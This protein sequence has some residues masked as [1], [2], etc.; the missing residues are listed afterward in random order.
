MKRLL[1]ICRRKSF[2]ACSFAA[3][4][5][6][7]WVF[8]LLGASIVPGTVDVRLKPS[9]ERLN[10]SGDPPC[11]IWFQDVWQIVAPARL[12]THFW[13]DIELRFLA[14]EAVL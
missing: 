5:F 1:L 12:Q 7:T 11:P 13:V 6:T 9:L 10:Q 2:S 14:I 3:F 8:L 4:A